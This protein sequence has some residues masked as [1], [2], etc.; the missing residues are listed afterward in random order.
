MMGIWAL[1]GCENNNFTNNEFINNSHVGIK[2]ACND[3]LFLNNLFQDNEYGLY[4][5]L[6]AERNL[7]YRNVFINNTFHAYDEETLNFWDNGMIGNYWDDYNGTDLN[8]DGIGDT[9][10]NISGTTGNQDNFPLVNLPCPKISIMSPSENTTFGTMSPEFEISIQGIG[11]YTIWYTIDN[12]IHNYTI[13]ELGGTINL[14]AWDN[15]LD[16]FITIQFYIK[17]STGSIGTSLV[18]VVK[19]SPD[20]TTP[21]IPGYNLFTLCGV[22]GIISLIVLRR[23]KFNV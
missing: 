17:D 18:I 1:W 16:G 10:Y 2:S 9:P 7:V 19:K 20:T 11:I 21:G 5:Y 3:D 8:F 13:I 6:L 23:R 15:A 22:C 4:F 12:G 14:T